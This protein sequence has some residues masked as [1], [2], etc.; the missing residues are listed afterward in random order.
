LLAPPAGG[1]RFLW[2]ACGRGALGVGEVQAA[3]KKRLPAAQFLHGA[4][5]GPG[6][7]LGS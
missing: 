5:L 2:V 4:R 6:A 3:G 7:R 1:E